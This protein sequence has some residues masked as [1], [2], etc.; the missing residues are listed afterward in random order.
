MEDRVKV[1]ESLLNLKSELEKE[2]FS[3]SLDYALEFGDQVEALFQLK[4]EAVTLKKKIAYCVQRQYR[5]Q[6]INAADLDHYIDEEILEYQ[7]K[8]AEL[9]AFNNAAKTSE[10][11]SITFSDEKKIRKLYFEIVHLIHPD[12][13]PEYQEIAGISNLWDKAVDAYKRNDYRTLVQAY[14]QILLLVKPGEFQIADLE[15]KIVALQDEIALIKESEPYTF[16]F[17]LNEEEEIQAYHD[18]LVKEIS[19]YEE[20]KQSLERE[21]ERFPIQRRNEA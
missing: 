9:I 3:L 18:K 16:K 8:L 20:Y 12:L 10:S 14:D 2:C 7:A 4:V 21:L 15:T 5:N 6:E 17:I 1:Y 13:H 11:H 19:D